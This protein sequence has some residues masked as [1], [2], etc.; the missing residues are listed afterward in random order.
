MCLQA[1]CQVLEKDFWS[2]AYINLFTQI[3]Y[4]FFQ[5]YA[6]VIPLIS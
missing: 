2:E 4:K 3:R 1:C 6:G 5:N